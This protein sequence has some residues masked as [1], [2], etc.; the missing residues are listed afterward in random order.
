MQAQVYA[1]VTNIGWAPHYFQLK[2]CPQNVAP[3]NFT[4]QVEQRGKREEKAIMRVESLPEGLRLYPEEFSYNCD[5]LLEGTGPAKGIRLTK[6]EVAQV[7]VENL[8]LF[9]AK[10][11]QGVRYRLYSPAHAAGPRPLML[12]LHGGGEGGTDNFTQMVGTVGALRLAEL[13]P[14]MY[15]MA[16]QAPAGKPPSSPAA[17][18]F[19]GS[20]NQPDTGWHRA[21]LAAVCDIIRGLVAAGKVDSNRVLVTGMSMGGGGTLRA[22]SVGSGLFAAAVPI[23]PTMTPE[24]Y[25]ILRSL[26]D[27]KIWVAA[28]Y[29]DHTIYRHKYIVDGILALRDAGNQDAHL[30]IFSPE[31]LAAYGLGNAPSISL[32]EKFGQNHACWMLVYNGEHGIMEWLA[33]QHK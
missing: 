29:V 30:T 24:T 25:G 17:Q 7:E 15:V 11:E 10:E 20:I 23:C 13:Y 2:G 26:T 33:S 18:S 16:P 19:S 22:L 5:F 1:K 12:F 3:E 6:Q 27:T 9:A 31:E 21:Y 14:D 32:E 8:E 4:L 28:A